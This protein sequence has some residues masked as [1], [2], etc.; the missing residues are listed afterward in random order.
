MEKEKRLENK[1]QLKKSL[2]SGGTLWNKF[3]EFNLDKYVRRRGLRVIKL[4][5]PDEN[6]PE[7]HVKGFVNDPNR[8]EG[9]ELTQQDYEF[10]NQLADEIREE[11]NVKLRYTTNELTYEQGTYR[12]ATQVDYYIT[13]EVNESDNS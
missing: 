12:K 7:E 10:F 9:Q 2:E 13:L 4:E 11:P 5:K 1:E 3:R 6:K 8:E